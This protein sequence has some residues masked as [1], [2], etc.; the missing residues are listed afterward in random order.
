MIGTDLR[1]WRNDLKLTQETAGARFGV[2][3]YTVQKWES[4]EL[5]V[6]SHVDQLAV[7]ITREI[8]QRQDDFPVQLAY[9]TSEPWLE[10][11][12]PLAQIVLKEFPNNTA[13][14]RDVHQMIQS[15][16][17]LH[18][19]TVIEKGKPGISIWS[20]EELLKEIEQPASLKK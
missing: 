3:R 11:G 20:R 4:G 2:S 14:L 17:P 18:L 1:E 13:M 10:S 16:N 15:G 7:F 19:A 9:A 8:K 12:R 5:D 6:P